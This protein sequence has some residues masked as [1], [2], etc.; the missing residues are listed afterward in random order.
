MATHSSIV[1][2]EIPWAEEPDGLL[3]GCKRVRHNPGTKTNNNSVTSHFVFPNSLCL[4]YSLLI[5]SV[6][7]SVVS[8]CL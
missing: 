5:L 1:A 8:D 4:L 2:Y 7:C 3:W 6:S